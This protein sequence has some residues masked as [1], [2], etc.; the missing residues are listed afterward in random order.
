MASVARR[1]YDAVV[2]G[3]GP[4]GLA[5]AVE[6]A[7][8]GRSVLVIEGAAVSGGGARSEP[9]TLPGF[10]HDVCSAVHPLGIASP[11]L[12]QLP[13]A[14]HGLEWVQPPIA[15]AHPLD[16]GTAAALERSVRSTARRLGPDGA[17]YGMLVG[18]FVRQ[19]EALFQDTLGPL[20]RMPRH[21]VLL[22]R[23]GLRAL[24]PTTVLARR[25]FKE[26]PARA[27]FAGIASHATL[28]L[29]Q[30][31]SAAFA[32]VLGIA[33]HGAGWP[34]A[35]GGSGAIATALVSYL[36]SLGGDV[37]TGRTVNSLDD[38][39]HARATLLDLTPQ[40]LLAMG[41]APLPTGYRKQLEH[42]QYGLGTF[43][44]DWALDRPIPWRAAECRLAGTVHLGGTLAEM[45]AGRRTEWQ[46]RPA[47]HPY[48]LVTQP[49]LFDPSRAPEGK[50]V[51]WGYCH[52]PNGSEVDMTARI[53]A[54]IERFA[55]GFRDRILARHV[56][57]PAAL[58]QHDPNLIGGDIG[59]GEST[60]RQMVFRPAVRLS[61]YTTPLPGVFLCSSSTPPGGGVHG[62]CGYHAARAA[63]RYIRAR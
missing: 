18:P 5:A 19:Y 14:A 15:A 35:R 51:A 32:L 17:A 43:K 63:L 57:D 30:T 12:R 53:E 26:E 60:L 31:P 47:E 1:Q 55:P 24:W 52:V 38:L 41:G 39:P 46:G 56:M 28:P 62:L 20:L 37:V 4:N 61:P 29:D 42:F 25:L 23:F 3:S 50:Q 9:L 58:Q 22:A 40:Q 49:S 7:R 8:A 27:L 36:R 2:V 59:G 10:V 34:F 11:F 44:V 6:L 45:V 16:D 21:P 33:G 13:L 48:V 54:Q